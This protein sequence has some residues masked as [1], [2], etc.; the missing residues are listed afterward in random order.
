MNPAG[1]SIHC[2]TDQGRQRERNEDS[3]AYHVP[4]DVRE[5]G[6][7]GTL[8]VVAD[9]MGGIGRGDTASKLAVQSVLD[10]YRSSKADTPLDGLRGALEAANHAVHAEKV[11]HSDLGPMGATCTA[12]VIRGREAFLAHVGDSRA[13][14]V[15]GRV[16]RQLTADHSLV[17]Q[18]V[19][20]HRLAPEKAHTD[21]RRNV[22]TRGL[23]VEPTVTVDAFRL[24][25]PLEFGDTLVLCTDGLHG[26]IGDDE[27]GALASHSDPAKACQDLVELANERGGPDNITVMLARVGTVDAGS[28]LPIDSAAGT[29]G[30]GAMGSRTPKESPT[31]LA[32][33][34]RLRLV[35]AI[36]GL[37][38]VLA[39]LAV[40]FGYLKEPMRVLG[41]SGGEAMAC[42]EAWRA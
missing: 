11:R 29:S 36:L 12:A 30:P 8:L 26:Q 38:V 42:T 33:H 23:G 7:Q 17:A 20:E 6:R 18:L 5:Q 34:V 4:D 14:L 39:L 35:L 22:V 24:E 37:L 32:R 16:A 9:G 1:L 27:L 31:P 3:H 21:P 19:R 41:F 13:Y 28:S 2:I 15:R 40:L 25:D 10:A